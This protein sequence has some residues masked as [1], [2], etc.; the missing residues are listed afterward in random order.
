MCLECLKAHQMPGRISPIAQLAGSAFRSRNCSRPGFGNVWVA[1]A[2]FDCRL[3]C[4]L[5]AFRCGAGVPTEDEAREAVYTNVLAE[6]RD[7]LLDVL[8][9]GNT[10]IA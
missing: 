9:N 1:V 7:R 10:L 2:C 3:F 5:A 8:A 6:L 4:R